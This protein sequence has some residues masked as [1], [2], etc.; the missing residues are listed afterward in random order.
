MPGHVA[1]ALAPAIPAALALLL[2]RPA[3][4]GWIPPILA[5]ATLRLAAF[6]VSGR[7]SPTSLGV[8]LIRP[9]VATCPEGA[10]GEARAPCVAAFSL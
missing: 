7:A 9:A 10:T 4:R 8:P 2:H 1:F 6:S 3:R 5:A